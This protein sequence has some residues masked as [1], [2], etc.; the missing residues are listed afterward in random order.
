[1]VGYKLQDLLDTEAG[2]GDRS[3]VEVVRTK[4]PCDKPFLQFIHGGDVDDFMHLKT[5]L[6]PFQLL[7]RTYQRAHT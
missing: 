5:G 3:Q 7:I 1:M 2:I 4:Q 6:Y